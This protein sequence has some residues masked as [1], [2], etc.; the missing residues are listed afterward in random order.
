M[1]CYPCSTSGRVW[2]SACDTRRH[3]TTPFG[4]P[5]TVTSV[6]GPPASAVADHSRSPVSA[7]TSHSVSLELVFD[8][9]SD[10]LLLDNYVS[11][12]KSKLTHT[13]KKKL[14]K[15]TISLSFLSFSNHATLGISRLNTDAPSS[16]WVRRNDSSNACLPPCFRFLYRVTSPRMR[17]II[18]RNLK[19]VIVN[20]KLLAIATGYSPACQ[21]ASL[22]D[23]A[24]MSVLC[25]IP[26]EIPAELSSVQIEH[27][28][29]EIH[30]FQNFSNLQNLT[31]STLSSVRTLVR[32][33]F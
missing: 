10:L 7:T 20:F 11:Y 13:Q 4:P 26:P 19:F 27:L 24:A 32:N 17:T 15:K 28:E 16:F 25:A 30:N 2:A 6:P 33:I 12:V 31:K 21:L 9:E 5:S 22:A 1:A 3:R 29:K 8:P 23:Q 14:N 18:S